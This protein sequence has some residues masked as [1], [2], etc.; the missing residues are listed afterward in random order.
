MIG[1]AHSNAAQTEGG[2]GLFFFSLLARLLDGQQDK[3]VPACF[4][5]RA[6]DRLGGFATVFASYFPRRLTHPPPPCQ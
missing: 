4:G 3:L 1:Y 5:G 6:E 2:D